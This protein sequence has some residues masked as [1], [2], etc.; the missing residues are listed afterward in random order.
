MNDLSTYSTATF[1]WIV[2]KLE[3]FLCQEEAQVPH[4]EEPYCAHLR[5]R[6][7]RERI[8]HKKRLLGTNLRMRRKSNSESLHESYAGSQPDSNPGRDLYKPN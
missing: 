8:E 3:K 2:T 6:K 5:W 1:N 4:E 7:K